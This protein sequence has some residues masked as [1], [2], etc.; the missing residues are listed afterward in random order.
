MAALAAG[1]NAD[2]KKLTM[3]SVPKIVRDRLQAAP[4]VVNHPDA[5]LLAAFAEQSLPAAER[6]TVLEHLARCGDCRDVVALALPPTEM[7]ET[8]APVRTSWLTWPVLRWGFVAAGVVIVASIGFLQL[9]K[10]SESSRI[11]TFSSPTDQVARNEARPQLTVATPTVPAA[12]QDTGAATSE[13]DE[14][15]KAAGG[16][17]GGKVTAPAAPPSSTRLQPFHGVAS[18]AFRGGVGGPKPPSQFLTNNNVQQQSSNSAPAPALILPQVSPPSA[19]QSAGAN[20]GV[21]LGGASSTTDTEGARLGAQLR[22]RSAGSQPFADKSTVSKTK[23]PVTQ[24]APGQITGFVVDPSGAVV[25]NAH[26][27]VT[28]ATAGRPATAVTDSQ[29]AFLI[30]GLSTGN[31]KAQAQAPGFNT[32]VQD[33]NFDASRPSTYNFTLNVGSVSETVEV[34][35]QNAQIQAETATMGGPVTNSMVSQLPINGRNYTELA[36]VSPGRLP[37]WTVSAGG[38][39][40]RSVDQGKNWQTVDVNASPM[41]SATL[42]IVAGESRKEELSKEKGADKKRLKREV[43]SPVF[44]AV[45]AA[46]SEVWAGGSGGALYHSLDAGIHWTRIVPTAAGTTLTGDIVSLEFSD[47]QNGKVTTSIPEVWIT[48]DA[49]QTWQKQ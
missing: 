35:A 39:L 40:Q 21:A 45:T 16:A 10:H 6:T 15:S 8:A 43:A 18:G 14:P 2:S 46:G 4:P 29:G 5:D 44:R 19:K 48:S 22:D 3:K 31:Y 23:L 42:E 47:S 41:S 30:A 7:L 1:S 37:R 20:E 12:K 17:A 49:G 34:T 24:P 36:S 11:A 9:Q 28:P 26:I 25:P 27:T 33:L 13:R 32:T 38:A